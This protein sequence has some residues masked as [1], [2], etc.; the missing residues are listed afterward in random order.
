VLSSSGVDSI[1]GLRESIA[2]M[3]KAVTSLGEKMDALLRGRSG[4]E[5]GE[6]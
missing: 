3:T 5:R 6:T 1:E 4:Q 2:A